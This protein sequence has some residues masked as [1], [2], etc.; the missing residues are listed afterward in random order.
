M[1]KV[2]NDSDGNDYVIETAFQCITIRRCMDRRG[3]S[4]CYKY[5]R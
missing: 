2:A 3:G 4:V 1:A 5:D